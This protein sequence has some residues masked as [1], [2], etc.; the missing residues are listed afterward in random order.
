MPGMPSR[1]EDRD[2][3]RPYPVTMP[4]GMLIGN[5]SSTCKSTYEVGG[6]GM[7]TYEEGGMGTPTC[8]VG[9]VGTSA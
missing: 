3:C 7:S 9:V 4:I 2:Q 8:D 1:N 5:I 6:M